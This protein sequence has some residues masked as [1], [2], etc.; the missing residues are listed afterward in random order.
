M[1]ADLDCIQVEVAEARRGR[2]DGA[3][4]RPSRQMFSALIDRSL[5]QARPYQAF[6]TMQYHLT[7]CRWRCGAAMGNL[8]H[9]GSFPSREKIAPSHSGIKR[10]FG[11][12]LPAE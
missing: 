9:K 3:L 7:D 12:P 11:L 2:A 6:L 4:S 8:A 10:L 5:Q 1:A